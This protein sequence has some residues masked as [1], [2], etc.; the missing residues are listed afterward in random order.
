[1]AEKNGIWVCLI[2]VGL[3]VGSGLFVYWKFHQKKPEFSDRN[4]N[5]T[6]S[7]TGDGDYSRVSDAIRAAPSNGAT[8]FYIHVCAGTYNEVVVVPLDKTNL[9]LVGDGAQV[10]KIT[11]NR[12]PPQYPTSDSTT[13]T[14]Y[15]DGFVAQDIA[16]ENNA[17]IDNGQAV[18]VSI[19]ANY[20]IFYRCSILGY[21]DTLYAKEGNQFF[22]E[23]DIYGTVDFIFGF[24]SAVFQRCNLYGRVS[25]YE[26]VTY[27]AQGRQSLDQKSAFTIQGCKITVAPDVGPVQPTMTGFL[28]RPWFPYS[29]VMVM[30]SFLDSIVNASGWEEWMSTPATHATYL[31][32]RNWGPGADTSGR[33]HWPGFKVVGDASGALPYTVSQLIQ[34]DEWIPR[35][36]VPYDSTFL[37]N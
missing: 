25:K 26:T 13:F 12:H 24:A 36:G 11:A 28:G 16:F 23:C 10:T 21:H 29:T 5:L 37:S 32:Y 1:M 18:A 7:Q 8:P 3:L 4:F 19:T 20:T 14:V 31:E 27:T 30:E 2:I 6:V 33:V 35:T 9:V 15:G 34:G 17:G 22:R